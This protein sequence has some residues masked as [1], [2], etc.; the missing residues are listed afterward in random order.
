MITPIEAHQLFIVTYWLINSF[1][2]I[3]KYNF[4]QLGEK[5]STTSKFEK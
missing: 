3:S 4:N 5:I 2:I 1:I